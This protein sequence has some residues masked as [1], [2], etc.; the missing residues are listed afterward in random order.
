MS[1]IRQDEILEIR[2]IRWLRRQSLAADWPALLSATLCIPLPARAERCF[3]VWFRQQCRELLPH[4]AQAGFAPV[5]LEI[6]DTADGP[7]MLA[8]CHG[9]TLALKRLCIRLEETLPGG[10]LLD[11]DVMGQDLHAWNRSDLGLPPRRCFICGADAAVCVVTRAHAREEL[12][13][14]AHEQ[15]LAM[16]P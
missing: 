6:A 1:A 4:L 3:S 7:M 2:E 10:R 15:L 12:I 8:G 5:C 16:Q 13:S 11:L 9:D 14:F